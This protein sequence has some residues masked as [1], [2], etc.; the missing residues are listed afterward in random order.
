[1]TTYSLNIIIPDPVRFR[2]YSLT[3][4]QFGLRSCDVARIQWCVFTTN[5]YNIISCCCL[6]MI[7]YTYV[8]CLKFKHDDKHTIIFVLTHQLYSICMFKQFQSLD[9]QQNRYMLQVPNAL[10][11]LLMGFPCLSEYIYNLYVFTVH[12]QK[13]NLYIRHLAKE[14]KSSVANFSAVHWVET[15]FVL[16]L[17][18]PDPAGGLFFLLFLTPTPQPKSV[19][20]CFWF[21]LPS[22]LL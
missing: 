8:W 15:N 10:G 19:L 9:Q 7:I 18:V 13:T 2:R 17:V 14:Q 20:M 4:L 16:N 6:G 1:M 12:V 3:Q 11:V 5:I 22:L 21:G